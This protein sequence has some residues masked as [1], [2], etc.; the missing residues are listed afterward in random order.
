MRRGGQ[1]LTIRL[2][3]EVMRAERWLASQ[4]RALGMVI[5]ILAVS[6]D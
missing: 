6:P 4:F 2:R 5:V 1:H 3:P